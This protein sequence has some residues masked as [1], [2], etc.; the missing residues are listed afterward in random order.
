[1]S[2]AGS[3]EY[4]YED[5][6]YYIVAA[7]PA[8]ALS[9]A[10][11]MAHDSGGDESQPKY[12]LVDVGSDQPMLELEGSIFRGTNDELL[13]TN[14]IFDTGAGDAGTE[15]AS[16]ELIAKTSRVISFYAVNVCQK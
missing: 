9:K 10:Y 16:A 1:M 3:S 15:Q 14:L 7:L 13:G 12:A 5:E 8:D 4:E 2:T 11:K 6:E